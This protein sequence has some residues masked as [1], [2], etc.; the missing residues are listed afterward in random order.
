MK[1]LFLDDKK[2]VTRLI[3]TFEPQLVTDNLVEYDGARKFL[4]NYDGLSSWDLVIDCNY[5][6]SFHTEII[7]QCNKF[8]V[9]S[10]LLHD[11][12]FEWKNSFENG[13]GYNL[14]SSIEHDM[15]FF[16]GGNKFKSYLENLTGKE[17][18]PYIPNYVNK[19][20]SKNENNDMK[21]DFLITT[22]NKCYFDEC[23]YVFL[24]DLLQS[25]IDY[26][27]VSDFTYC[28]RIF[29]DKILNELKAING[30]NIIGC[31]LEDAL[32]FVSGGV[33]TT[34]STLEFEV[35]Q[36]DFP[37][38]ELIYRDVPIFDTPGWILFK[39]SNYDKIFYSMINP[40]KERMFHQ[41][42]ILSQYKDTDIL[43]FDELTP[44]ELKPPFYYKARLVIKKFANM[45]RG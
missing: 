15:F 9:A 34:K 13:L 23:E 43:C 32:K 20:E 11:G 33:V 2:T 22:A 26:F 25:I 17:C 35:M 16:F 3:N 31:S 29:D 27:N 14:Y 40:S 1:I 42:N 6:N 24:I 21:Y 5:T 44:N 4:F 10:I 38:C 18:I 37:V 8:E 30:D 19:N 41:K 12:I 36:L 28:L 45:V 39:G 7:R